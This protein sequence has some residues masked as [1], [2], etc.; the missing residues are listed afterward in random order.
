MQ[1]RKRNP[2][3]TK[4]G[5]EDTREGE[6]RKEGQK[7]EKKKP[8]ELSDDI[9]TLTQTGYRLE[10]P[11]LSPSV[12]QVFRESLTQTLVSRGCKGCS[13]YSSL[14]TMQSGQGAFTSAPYY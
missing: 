5:E 8:K 1:S 6:R 10:Q 11:K 7:R 4:E 14:R 12:G 13:D 9:I 3:E 2:R